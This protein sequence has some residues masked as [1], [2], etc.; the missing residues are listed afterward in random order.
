[1]LHAIRS[2]VRARWFT[3][4]AIVTFA[5][6]IGTNIAVFALV[7][8]LLFR[9]LPYNEPQQLF[10]LQEVDLGTGQRKASLPKRYVDE[11]RTRLA[12]LDQRMAM[13]GDSAGYYFTPDMDGP[14]LRL[15]NVT[16]QMPAILGLNPVQGRG[17]NED[18]DRLKRAVVMLTYEGWQDRLGGAPDV[19]GRKL[20]LR[21]DA[22]E[23]IG[24][25]PPGFIPPGPFVDPTMVGIRLVPEVNTVSRGVLSLPPVVRI[26]G[27]SQAA[28]QA[29]L[30][31]LV[32]LVR[33][34]M[35]VEQTPS[36]IR[37]IPIRDAMPMFGDSFRE[38]T[39]HCRRL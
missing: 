8:R 16:Y 39:S 7:D 5:L 30:E 9:P 25:L 20:W 11:A 1:M 10:L 24:I 13:M 28:A 15:T 19:V 33:Q 37:F 21:D 38:G 17:F 34:E 23:V 35:P 6:G 2:L 18:D 29:E 4:G 22:F 3:A 36:S 31:A 27:V 14:E 32:K 12:F 26:R